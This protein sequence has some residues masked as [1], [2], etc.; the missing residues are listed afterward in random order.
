MSSPCAWCADSSRFE[1]QVRGLDPSWEHELF[2]LLPY[3]RED[4]AQLVPVHLT[5]SSKPHVIAAL[6]VKPVSQPLS[7]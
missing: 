4:P 2:R 3:L 7:G 6:Q 5:K 1:L